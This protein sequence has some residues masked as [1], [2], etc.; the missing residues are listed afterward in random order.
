MTRFEMILPLLK[1]IEH[2]ILDDS[3]S[4]VMINGCLT[5]S[6]ISWRAGPPSLRSFRELLPDRHR[7]VQFIHDL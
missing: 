6:P 2:L 5:R 1:P 4:E 3:I 7:P